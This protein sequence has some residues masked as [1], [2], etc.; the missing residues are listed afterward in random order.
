VRFRN[1]LYTYG[2]GFSFQLGGIAKLTEELRLG[3]SFESPTWYRLFDETR[4]SLR[5]VREST[6]TPAYF[7]DGIINVYPE[8]KVQTP[9]KYTIR[10]E[11]HT[12]ELQSRENLVCR[13]L[14]EKKKINKKKYN[15][16]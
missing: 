8:Y 10:S 13:L 15:K 9:M 16:I 11:E 12:S 5:T 6:T 7:N 4:Q 14:L 3:L 1:E 2:S